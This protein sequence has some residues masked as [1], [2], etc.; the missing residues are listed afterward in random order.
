MG[1]GVGSSNCLPKSAWPPTCDLAVV[2]DFP[3]VFPEEV[4]E[5]PPER[6]VEVEAKRS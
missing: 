4:N 3:D 2:C 1:Q 5:L 6:E